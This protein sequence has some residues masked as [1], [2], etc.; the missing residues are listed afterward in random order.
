MYWD[1]NIHESIDIRWFYHGWVPPSILMVIGMQRSLLARW[2]TEPF[3][4]VA[5]RAEAGYLKYNHLIYNTSTFSLYDKVGN[6]MECSAYSWLSTLPIT[7]EAQFHSGKSIFEQQKL[8][9]TDGFPPLKYTAIIVRVT[10]NAS[11]KPATFIMEA[12]GSVCM[13]T[14]SHKSC[15]QSQFWM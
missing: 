3:S 1:V 4:Q 14:C 10:L 15:T 8:S 5:I 9:L 11:P 6:M 2:L 13:G 7:F 12:V